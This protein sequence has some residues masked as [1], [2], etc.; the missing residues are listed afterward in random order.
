M[1][2]SGFLSMSD[3][4]HSVRPSSRRGPFAFGRLYDRGLVSL[5]CG[6][7]D[8]PP[9]FLKILSGDEEGARSLV[10][11]APLKPAQGHQL[12]LP[13]PTKAVRGSKTS[14]A[15]SGAGRGHG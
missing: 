13:T 15:P 14:T 10:Q 3:P 2:R 11:T 9:H 7:P 6:I 5:R 4:R 1:Q 12:S 8:Y